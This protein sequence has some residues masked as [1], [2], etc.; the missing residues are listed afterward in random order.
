MKHSGTILLALV[1]TLPLAACATK[2][3]A[4]TSREYNAA[5]GALTNQSGR[6]CIRT[7][8]ILSYTPVSDN[9]LGLQVRGPKEYLLVTSYSCPAVRSAGTAFPGEFA[10]FCAGRDALVSGGERCPTLGLYEFESREAKLDAF[11]RVRDGLIKD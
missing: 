10:E 11:N 4:P 5:L 6:S 3:G 8:D 2:S 7:A 9:V 1:L